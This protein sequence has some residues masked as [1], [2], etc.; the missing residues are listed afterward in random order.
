MKNTSAPLLKLAIFAFPQVMLLL[1][2]PS[3]RADVISEVSADIKEPEAIKQKEPLVNPVK[4]LSSQN[5]TGKSEVAKVDPVKLDSVKLDSVKPD[6][7][8][9]DPVK[10]EAISDPKASTP[11]KGEDVNQK[12]PL[13]NQSASTQPASSQNVDGKSEPANIQL[14]PLSTTQNTTLT[15]KNPTVSQ[16]TSAPAP[17]S[18]PANPSSDSPRVT[19]LSPTVN[20]VMDIPAATVVIQS[21][22]NTKVELLVNGRKVDASSIGRSELDEA[23]KIITQTWYGVPLQ[24]GENI[25]SARVAGSELILSSVNV[26]VRGTPV[27][28]AINTLESRIPADGRSYATVDG[29]LV[30]ENGNRSN[31][32]AIVTLQ[33]SDGQFI[34]TDA[35]PEQPG[36]QVQAK[37]GKFTAQLKSG[38]KAGTI[39]IRAQNAQ[40]ETFTQVQFETDLRPSLVTG[41][42]DLR[43]GAR[44][45]DFYRSL[46][47]FL[48]TDRD[49]RT[50]VD[51]Y[52]AVFGTGR[53]GEW[54]VT[55][56]YNNSRTLNQDCAGN[57]SLFGSQKYCDEQ[58]PVY[59]DSS[60]SSRT[61]PS[62]DSLYLR[63]ERTSPVQG[64]SPDYFM[65]GN[66]NTEEFASRSQ[67]YT[68]ISRQLHGA[69]GNFNLGD[70]QITGFYSN[71]GK[72]FQRD[73]IAPNGTS[74][75]YFLSRQ[76]LV[77]GS[78]NI[79]VELVDFFSA[80]TVVSRKEAIR[81]KDYDIN[82][83]NGSLLFRQPLYQTELGDNG[84]LLRRQVVV[85]YQNEQGG[86]DSSIY[87][88]QL[89]YH[90]NRSQDKPTSIAVNYF[91]ES[92][93]IR[94]FVLYG[95]NAL[96][97]F[98][99]KTQLTAEYARS[100]NDSEVVGAVSGSA[101]R[102][103]L[104]S[105]ISGILGKIYYSK[106][107]TG[108]ANN[109][110][111][112]FV[113]GQTKF[114]TQLNTKVGFTTSLK[115]QYEQENNNGIAPR[116]LTS[117]TDLLTPRREAVPGS[118][119]DNSLR[120]ITLGLQQNIGSILLDLDLL[121]RD[122]QDRQTPNVLSSNSTQLRSRVS[123]PISQNIKFSAQNEVSLSSSADAVIPDRSVMSLDWTIVQGLT[124]RLGQ[125]WFHSGALAGSSITSADL[126]GEYKL[127]TDTSLTGRYSVIGGGNTT[128]TQGALGLNQRWQVMPGL[129]LGFGYERVFGTFAS[130]TTTA[131]GTQFQQPVAVGQSSS[132]LTSQSGDSY[133]IG[134]E[135][136]DNP[137]LKAS[138]KFENRSGN[139]SNN[140]VFTASAL[141]KLTPAVSVMFNYQQ[142]GA[143]NQGLS[144]LGTIANFKVGLAY[145]DPQDDKFN[146]LL[147]YEY[148]QNPSIIPESLL[149]GGG[150]GYVDHTLALEGIY[151]PNWQWEFYGKLALRNSTTTIAKDFTGVS[152]TNLTQF[153]VTYRAGYNV[154]LVGETRMLNQ[155]TAGYSELGLV[156]EVGYYLTPD[157]RLALGYSSGSINTDRDF[158]GSRSA[159]GLYAGI[160]VKLNEL[161]DGFGLQKTPPR[162]QKDPIDPQTPVA[163]EAKPAQKVAASPQPEQAQ[164]ISLN[165]ARSLTFKDGNQGDSAELA[166]ADI[167]ILENLAS[168][169]KEYNNLSID[170]QGHIGSLADMNSGENVAANRMMA[171]RKYLL[172]R[173]VTGNQMTLRSLGGLAASPSNPDNKVASANSSSNSIPISFALTGR[174]DIFN[175]I[176]TRL[177]GMATSTPASE[178]LQAILPKVE[179]ILQANAAIA[180]TN[181]SARAA[182]NTTV[183]V[184]FSNDGRI[185]DLSY[186]TLDR[187]IER[188][189]SNPNSTTEIQ[190]GSA[191]TASATQDLDMF[192]LTAVRNY[193]LEKGINSDR[194]L[195][196]TNTTGNNQA[197]SAQV[198]VSLNVDDGNT[199]IA[200]TPTAPT[201]QAS[202]QTTPTTQASSQ[203]TP[204]TQAS[205]QTTPTTQASSQTTPTTQASS[206]TTPPTQASATTTPVPLASADILRSPLA[207]LLNSGDRRFNSWIESSL[208]NLPFID[209]FNG[210]FNLQF[211]NTLEIPNVGVTQLLTQLPM[212][213][214]SLLL[215]IASV[216][217][218][219]ENNP[220]PTN[221]S[222][223]SYAF[224]A[225]PTQL[226]SK[227]LDLGTPLATANTEPT[228]QASATTEPIPLASANTLT[229]PLALLL[230]GS[231]R[232]FN[233]WIESSLP[234]FIFNSQGDGRFT[235][236][237]SNSF[238]V[239]NSGAT[240]LLTQ[241]PI[242]PEA[243]LLAIAPVDRSADKPTLPTAESNRILSYYFDNSPSQLVSLLLGSELAAN[244]PS[245]ISNNAQASNANSPDDSANRR[246]AT[247]FNFLLSKDGDTVT[248]FL[249]SLGVSTTE[250]S[251][252]VIDPAQFNQIKN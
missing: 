152:N 233:N 68:S 21:P 216:D 214:D 139:N 172:N 167:A 53:V 129:R 101:F 2:A 252:F 96:I 26:K 5:E 52:G 235:N 175:A 239:S 42:I 251:G 83:D 249:R 179:P 12:V 55:G 226:M 158:S 67:Q 79:F 54:L 157:L 119:V 180:P 13:T 91:K 215:A 60:T 94:N 10:P 120:T 221:S 232:R 250:K 35:S 166:I 127:G 247:A 165:V 57:S 77:S 126:L 81:G 107:D 213:T 49:N 108:F 141:G 100:E 146:A 32:D 58:Y 23:N 102:F 132:S 29:Q 37:Q 14:A 164:I 41:V 40:M 36:F 202:S 114:G 210:Q 59:G 85:T 153:R 204:T 138:I 116:P 188:L 192:K 15:P 76:L 197:V 220:A 71:V 201:T 19:I 69:K 225:S 208:P 98:T 151:A 195:I 178:F 109:A 110:T 82:Y 63:F 124:A 219:P 106:A 38:L 230:D 122:R 103:E 27:K 84:Q 87:G 61:A 156:G 140:T 206:Q 200:A 143:A 62:Y 187:L 9:P 242:T 154:E 168:V 66:F 246:L 163:Q 39:I 56:A 88:G 137:D 238:R 170:I 173:G 244:I 142:S 162:Q 130:A 118:L 194:I 64:A 17:T 193:L 186:A 243:L 199:N 70:V 3:V 160:T 78:E 115:F 228:A 169:L 149:I 89:R 65:W 47:E 80:G 218:N 117:L 236:Q 183:G 95:A 131:T 191:L 34:G 245:A 105:E 75:T 203:T 147:R 31:W 25:L 1:I 50:Q 181:P 72:G 18:T 125:Q 136:T 99:E 241:L 196:G 159:G 209:Q 86:S 48:P 135:Y 224:E 11:Q 134:L 20:S 45:S 112:S 182:T 205:S 51:L 240:Q 177:Q 8:K 184:N 97:S 7:V 123:V 43:V 248:A 133:N 217:N 44:G 4:V 150:S 46:R 128:S 234:D 28:L 6:P 22:S 211:I 237:F 90:L 222:L 113:P 161:F 223:W 231:D 190:A 121:Y 92:Q 104:N 93:G 189:N 176:A 171:A 33:A 227:L 24:A 207:L 212:T 229:S 145:R 74:G 198:Y 174:A 185:A 111:I 155:P 30:D 144:A 16:T 73:T 148:R